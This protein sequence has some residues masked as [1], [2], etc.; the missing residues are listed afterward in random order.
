[1]IA[2]ADQ[3]GEDALLVAHELNL[4][5]LVAHQ[6]LEL[7]L[8][9]PP[10]GLVV[11]AYPETTSAPALPD[12]V[13]EAKNLQVLFSFVEG[14]SIPVIVFLRGKD[15]LNSVDVPNDL[16][17]DVAVNGVEQ[18]GLELVGSSWGNMSECEHEFLGRFN[19]ALSRRL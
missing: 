12:L 3:T 18:K 14:S 6:R 15:Y 11:V 4:T 17:V 8:H 19:G 9:L 10:L 7:C 13:F 5:Q 1:M 2:H 16:L